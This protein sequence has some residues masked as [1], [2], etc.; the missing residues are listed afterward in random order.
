MREAEAAPQNLY[1]SLIL[2]SLL[3]SSTVKPK[4]TCTL[5]MS[6]KKR[7]IHWSM[8]GGAQKG[9]FS[10]YMCGGEVAPQNRYISLIFLSVL[11]TSAKHQ[12]STFSL[13]VGEKQRLP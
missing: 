10:T 4:S 8:C 7:I 13:S 12:K 3:S 1:I 2:L 11:L 9:F 6:T 5:A